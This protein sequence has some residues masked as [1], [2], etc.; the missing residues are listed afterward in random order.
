MT[1]WPRPH[2]ARH[3]A[4]GLPLVLAAAG[5]GLLA[6]AIHL[7]RHDPPPPAAAPVVRPAP[8]RRPADAASL[9]K[10]ALDYYERADRQARAGQWDQAIADLDRALR[11]QPNDPW[12]WHRYGLVLVGRGDVE[13]YRAVCRDLSRRFADADDP[14]TANAVLWLCALVPDAVEDY[15]PL[16]RLGE[17]AVAHKPQV[18]G[19]HEDLGAILFRAGRYEDAARSLRLAIELHGDDGWVE[20]QLFLALSLHALGQRDEARHWLGK[21]SANIQRTLSPSWQSRIWW[22]LLRQEAEGELSSGGEGQGRCGAAPG[23]SSGNST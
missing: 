3:L 4:R 21:A 14:D 15:A 22:R 6:L 9:R 10:E 13:A 1:R 8:V 12:F 20:T 23:R 17:R 16:L 2:L 19:Y 7:G 18:A 5:L 11:L